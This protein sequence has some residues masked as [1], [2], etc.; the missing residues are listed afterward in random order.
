MQWLLPLLL[1]LGRSGCY[2]CCCCWTSVAA[3]VVTA[4]AVGLQWLLP[5]S[6]LLLVLEMPCAA[7]WDHQDPHGTPVAQV[8]I[9]CD[10]MKGNELVATLRQPQGTLEQLLL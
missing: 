6:L 7:V 5:L 4:A 3:T 2:R 10:R 8:I 9:T 1:L